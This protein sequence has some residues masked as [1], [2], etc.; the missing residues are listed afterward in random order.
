MY[1]AADH[2]ERRYS[3]SGTKRKYQ[4]FRH[5]KIIKRSYN[6]KTG[7]Y[8]SNVVKSGNYYTGRQIVW[9]M[10]KKKP[11]NFGCQN[12]GLVLRNVVWPN[13]SGQ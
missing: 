10:W 8:T 4:C 9:R 5:Y 12:P 2:M 3:Q 7:Q 13:M 11:K 6:L 1:V